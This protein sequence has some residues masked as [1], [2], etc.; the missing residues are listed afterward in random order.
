TLISAP[1][2]HFADV[3]RAGDVIFEVDRV[4]KAFDKP[5]FRDLS[6]QVKRGQRLGILGPNGCGKTT[7][8]KILLGEMPPDSGDVRRGHL[9]TLGYLDQHLK[10]LPDEK[11]VLEAVWPKPDPSITSQTMRDLLGRFGLHGEMVDQ[12]VSE[13][14]GG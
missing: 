14:S 9:T 13:L 12:K 5:L 11:T 1:A 4:A 10:M 8:L 6:F 3:A 2:M 7:L